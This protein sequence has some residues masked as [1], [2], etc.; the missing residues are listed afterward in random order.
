VAPSTILFG[1]TP[2]S[3]IGVTLHPETNATH[4]S[5]SCAG[6]DQSGNTQTMPSASPTPSPGQNSNYSANGLPPGTYTCT[7]TVT[8]P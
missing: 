6:K 2:L 3:D 1:N 5:I 8:D 7:V 4:G